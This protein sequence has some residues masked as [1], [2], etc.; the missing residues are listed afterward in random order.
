MTKLP[1]ARGTHKGDDSILELDKRHLTF[2]VVAGICCRRNCHRCA[3]NLC[4]ATR[5]DYCACM[6]TFAIRVSFS[7]HD[8]RLSLALLRFRLT[9]GA[10]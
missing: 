5:S 4:G 2:L 6:C 3:D 1:S 8:A 9:I 7:M 10:A